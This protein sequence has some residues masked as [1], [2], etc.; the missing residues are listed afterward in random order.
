MGVT[1]PGWPCPGFSWGSLPIPTRYRGESEHA[2]PG[3]VHRG[4]QQGKVGGDLQPSPDSGSPTSVSAAHQVPDLAL[5][6]GSGGPV[7]GPP[8]RV[9]LGGA[10]PDQLGLAATDREPPPGRRGGALGG[11]RATP[12]GGRERRGTAAGLDGPDRRGEAG[13]AGHGAR[14]GLDPVTVPAAV[15]ILKRSWGSARPARAAA[16]P[17]GGCRRRPPPGRPAGRR[18]RRR[19]RRRPPAAPA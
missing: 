18:R 6:L 13:G 11:Q 8:G 12:A 1:A 19:R 17:C 16:R 10:G 4:G 7:L 5:H 9:G 2:E 15:S 14:G 3:Q